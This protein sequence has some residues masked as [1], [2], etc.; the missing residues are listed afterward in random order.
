[1]ILTCA[2]ICRAGMGSGREEG[3]KGWEACWPAYGLTRRVRAAARCHYLYAR[4]AALRTAPRHQEKL[5]LLMSRGGAPLASAPHHSQRTRADAAASASPRALRAWGMS[6]RAAA[7]RTC[8]A[9]AQR[10]FKGRARMPLFLHLCVLRG[11]RRGGRSKGLD[12]AGR[13]AGAG[14]EGEWSTLARIHATMTV[15]G[16]HRGRVLSPH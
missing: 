10:T 9:A 8:R 2:S 15:R 6:S 1:M 5:D 4:A 11:K 12:L 14:Q 13:K 16:S 3:G 7:Q